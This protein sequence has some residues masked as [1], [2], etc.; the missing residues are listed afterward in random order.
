MHIVTPFFTICSDPTSMLERE[1]GM[2][3]IRWS[4][5]VVVVNCDRILDLL[6]CLF[7]GYITRD[8]KNA[9]AIFLSDN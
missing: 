1:R 2:V 4:N 5:L 9:C 8:K 6:R 3:C 7:H